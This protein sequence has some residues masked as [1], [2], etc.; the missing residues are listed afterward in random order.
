VRKGEAVGEE[1]LVFTRR[2]LVLGNLGLLAW[3]ILA[4][5]SAL[6]YNQVYGW[7]YLIFLFIIAYAILRRLGCSS[8]YIC[9]DCTSGFGRLAGDFFGGGFVR[10][11]SVGNR[12]G[13]VA[14]LYVLLLPVPAAFLALA[15]F[16]VVSIAVLGCLL[17]LSVY[18]LSTWYRKLP[19]NR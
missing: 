13:L 8:C 9:K 18:S 1:K 11:E 10:K 2:F 5:A 4:S 17:A 19:I 6:F 3:I 12:L 7:L 16:S 14:F 15:G